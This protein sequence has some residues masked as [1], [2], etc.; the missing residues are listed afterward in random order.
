MMWEFI[1]PQGIYHTKGHMFEFAD[2]CDWKNEGQSR[3]RE[4][5]DKFDNILRS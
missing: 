2:L 3:L 4:I 1:S 5:H